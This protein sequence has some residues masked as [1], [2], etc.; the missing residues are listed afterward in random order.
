VPYKIPKGNGEKQAYR[1]VRLDNHI[2][3]H[4][5]NMKQ[6]YDN[7]KRM[8]LQQK[9][10]KVFQEWLGDLKKDVFIEY[11]IPLPHKKAG[12]AQK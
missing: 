3:K 9:K 12:I 11:K 10:Y 2:P 6:D 8:A 4:K 7:I 5:A 1:I